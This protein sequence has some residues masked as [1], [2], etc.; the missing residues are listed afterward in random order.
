M[1]DLIETIKRMKESGG[2]NF[3]KL[4][5]NM[6]HR[7]SI[8]KIPGVTPDM[9]M[10]AYNHILFESDETCQMPY[11]TMKLFLEVEEVYDPEDDSNNC[12]IVCE[13]EVFNTLTRIDEEYLDDIG[14]ELLEDILGGYYETI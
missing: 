11:E 10:E 8:G 4:L 5:E 3:P 12:E 14:V 9:I 1:K 6:K 13:S 7:A 2:E